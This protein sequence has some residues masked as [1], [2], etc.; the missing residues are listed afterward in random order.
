MRTRA[1]L[2]TIFFSGSILA[3]S[4]YRPFPESNA[5][6]VE[7]HAWLNPGGPSCADF[8]WISCARPTYFGTDTLIGATSYHRLRYHGLCN[9]QQAGGPTVLPPWCS[10][11]GTYAEPLQDFI[12]I[13]QDVDRKSVV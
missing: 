13:R 9:W 3:Q 2:L 11:S 10:W 12:Y 4:P 1:T 8:T 7:S 6:W 5:G